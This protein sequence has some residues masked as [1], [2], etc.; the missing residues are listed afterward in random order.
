MEAWGI[1]PAASTICRPILLSS[2]I[3]WVRTTPTSNGHTLRTVFCPVRLSGCCRISAPILS[4][5]SPVSDY[6]PIRSEKRRL[7]GLAQVPASAS[8]L[9]SGHCLPHLRAKCFSDGRNIPVDLQAL[10]Y[11][12]DFGWY[13]DRLPDV[14][15][16]TWVSSCP[17]C[18]LPPGAGLCLSRQGSPHL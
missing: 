13:R 14:E 12:V 11:G 1:N 4:G 17:L 10:G 15:A 2:A 6:L 3:S 5:C 18:S 7:D 8:G 9:T 16:T